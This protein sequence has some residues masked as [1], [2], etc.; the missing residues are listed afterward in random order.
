MRNLTNQLLFENNDNPDMNAG[1]PSV[2]IP[3]IL[4]F[5]TIGS[6]VNDATNLAIKYAVTAPVYITKRKEIQSIYGD[7]N[8]TATT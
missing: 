3:P 6:F 8:N 5:K 4:I 1:A 7:T 2:V